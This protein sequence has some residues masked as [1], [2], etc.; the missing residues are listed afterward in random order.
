MLH[1]TAPVA[2]PNCTGMAIGGLL[3]A[4]PAA[5]GTEEPRKGA[6]NEFVSDIML[7]VEAI[8]ARK[9]DTLWRRGQAELT[10][11][12]H[13]RKEA[14]DTLQELTARQD[15]LLEEQ[16]SM[17]CALGDI[18]RNLEAVATEMREA[19]RSVPRPG[20]DLLGQGSGGL[21]PNSPPLLLSPA[22]PPGLSEQ[23]WPLTARLATADAYSDRP[24]GPRTPPRSSE[25]TAARM[26]GLGLSRAVGAYPGSPAVLLSL[27]SALPP[28]VTPPPVLPTKRL[29]IA[30]CLDM[31]INPYAST[32]AS[33]HPFHS[34]LY[35]MGGSPSD[36]L[37]SPGLR[38]EAPAF[39]PGNGLV[40]TVDE[41]PEALKPRRLL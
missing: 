6:P 7:E 12:H 37:E 35:S 39:V 19:L 23:I 31:A 3:E 10:K 30:E 4:A 38:A 26:L 17:R 34:A 13:D 20:F 11:L 25:M 41:G 15:M 1:R 36:G 40:R 5:Q 16:R 8:L 24:E 22:H 28:D 14:L 18:T 2:K 29:H 32:E 27:A 9:A 21:H 33:C